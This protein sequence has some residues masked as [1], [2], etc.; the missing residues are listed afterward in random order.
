MQIKMYND[1]N[2]KNGGYRYNSP[3]YRARLGTKSIK[4]RFISW[5]FEKTKVEASISPF[6]KLGKTVFIFSK[7][8]HL[9]KFSKGVSKFEMSRD[10]K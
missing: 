2:Q 3:T 1:I 9:W 7:F 4:L 5:R 10:K 8:E 6:M